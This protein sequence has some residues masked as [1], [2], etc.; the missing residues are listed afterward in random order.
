MFSQGRPAG[1]ETDR[2]GIC[3][4]IYRTSHLFFARCQAYREG[5]Q[6]RH[7]KRADAE[8]SWVSALRAERIK[9]RRN[10]GHLPIFRL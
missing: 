3:Q 9:L 5:A 1:A 7:R 8:P 4:Q 10:D 2:A 6:G